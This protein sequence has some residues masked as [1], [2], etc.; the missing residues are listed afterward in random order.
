MSCGQL[1]REVST[2]SDVDVQPW[3]PS[4]PS[5][6]PMEIP[7]RCSRCLRGGRS[8]AS[9]QRWSIGDYLKADANSLY[10][11]WPV[12]LARIALATVAGIGAQRAGISA[13][14]AGFRGYISGKLVSQMAGAIDIPT[15]LP[16]PPLV[17][18]TSCSLP[19]CC[20]DAK[21]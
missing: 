18:V 6:T 2:P 20:C 12:G 10:G 4:S 16:S 19:D 15:S 3:A 14:N 17:L 21:P 9:P 5:A 8:L 7:G 1:F 11:T 13:A